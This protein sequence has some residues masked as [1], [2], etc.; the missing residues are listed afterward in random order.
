MIKHFISAVQT[1]RRATRPIQSEHLDLRDY[2]YTLRT[3]G[4]EGDGDV[5]VA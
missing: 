3:V 1:Q 4:S 5:F 2:V